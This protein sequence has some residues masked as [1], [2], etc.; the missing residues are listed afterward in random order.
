MPTSPARLPRLPWKWR[1]LLAVGVGVLVLRKLLLLVL[2][3]A[4]AWQ[5]PQVQ[6]WVWVTML[7]HQMRQPLD[8]PPAPSLPAEAAAKLATH[9]AGL[10]AAADLF[11]PTNVWDVHLKFTAAQWA[12][13]GPN[14]VPPIPGFIR[15][16]GTVILRNPKAARPGLAGVLGIDQPWSEADLD[17]G[18]AVLGDTGARFKGNG[19]FI[20]AQRSYKR[21]FK[22][23]LNKHVPAQQ[24]A[25]RA[26]LNFHN[27]VADASC[28]SD[29]LAYEFFRDA[30]VPAPRTAFARL[31]LTVGGRF[32]GRLLGLYVLVENPDA[33]WAREEFGVAGVTLFKPVTYE[34]FKDLGDDWSAYADIYAPKTKIKARH[35]RRLMELARLIT[36]ASDAEFAA[37]IGEFVDLAEFARFFACQ[38][39]LANYDGI[40]S[41]G[42]NFLLYLDPRTSRFGFIPWDLDH[43]W[44]E[45]PHIGTTAQREQAS[46]WH[47]WVGENHFLERMLA[48]PS[49]RARY[50]QE[51]EQLRNT[52]FLPER[53]SRRT[54]ELAAVVRPFVAEESADRLAKFERVVAGRRPAGPRDGKPPGP[55][56]VGFSLK[57]FFSARAAAVS[58]QL[59]GRAEGVVLTRGRTAEAGSPR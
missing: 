41:N 45:F 56:P 34:L 11:R 51:L 49:V 7:N 54:D 5:V 23:H 48:T 1:L 25:G 16:D 4:L 24:L 40:L 14:T 26:T 20:G 19:T 27:L 17:F 8:P 9:A 52:L 21:P 50:R 22:I 43:C 10:R 37:R 42:Q 39:I 30:G 46:L 58:D 44:G 32:E 2:G 12:A 18:D 31:R 29:A 57:H 33:Q 3:C 6:T 36:H 38:V 13:L 53:L 55:G 35:Q 15:P 28:L 59:E 47:P